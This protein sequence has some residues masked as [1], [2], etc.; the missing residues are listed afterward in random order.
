MFIEGSH[1]DPKLYIQKVEN[2]EKETFKLVVNASDIYLT[3]EEKEM[4]TDQEQ[5]VIEKF[6]TVDQS[7]A[8]VIPFMILVDEEDHKILWKTSTIYQ[9][10]TKSEFAERFKYYRKMQDY[11]ESESKDLFYQVKLNIKDSQQTLDEIWDIIQNHLEKANV[12]LSINK[13]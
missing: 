11:L 7:N 1:I 9:N 4:I 12:D 3:E 2:E 13:S 8:I 5:I 10:D 6:Q